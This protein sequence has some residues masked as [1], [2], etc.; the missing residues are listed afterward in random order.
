MN[1]L[2]LQ[3][4]GMTCEHCERALTAELSVLAAVEDLD[5]DV[6]TGRVLITHSMALDRGE[7]ERAIADA[8][9]DLE[10]SPSEDNA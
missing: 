6:A 7:V 8:G 5:I 4:N 2:E 3:V 9:F 10:Q 1:E